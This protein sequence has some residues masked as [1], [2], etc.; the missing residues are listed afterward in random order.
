MP[1]EKFTGVFRLVDRGD[2]RGGAIRLFFQDLEKKSDPFCLSVW[3]SYAYKPYR[4]AGPSF[5]SE[6]AVN[7]L[8]LIVV[9]ETSNGRPALMAA[10]KVDPGCDPEAER[11]LLPVPTRPIGFIRRHP[12]VDAAVYTTSYTQHLFYMLNLSMPDDEI[13]EVCVNGTLDTPPYSLLKDMVFKARCDAARISSERFVLTVKIL[14]SYYAERPNS[15]A[16]IE[17]VR[18][19]FIQKYP[20]LEMQNFSY[21]HRSFNGI[22]RYIL[23]WSLVKDGRV[24]RLDSL[25]AFI[26]EIY[27]DSLIK[28]E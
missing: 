27:D 25:K 1:I 11:L 9:G 2:I 21:V 14:P 23:C 19:K 10:R 16:V 26:S 4:G 15:R 22:N 17:D 5:K 13:F 3:R 24:I 12:T 18:Q 7:D 20:K 28:E 6:G 8:F